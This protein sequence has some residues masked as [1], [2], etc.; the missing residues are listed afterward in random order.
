MTDMTSQAW[1]ILATLVY[2][3][4]VTLITGAAILFR[5]KSS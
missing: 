5:D 4:A 3:S 1:L 2:V